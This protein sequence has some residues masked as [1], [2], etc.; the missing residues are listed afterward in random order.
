[1]RIKPLLKNYT[2]NLWDLKILIEKTMDVTQGSQLI[3][4][5]PNI[6]CD[7]LIMVFNTMKNLPFFSLQ[8]VHI[9]REKVMAFQIFE[10]LWW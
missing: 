1:M 4:Q 5:S 8:I 2:V 6:D 10:F 9:R 3:I 7:N